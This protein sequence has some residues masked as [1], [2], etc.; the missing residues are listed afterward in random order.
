MYVTKSDKVREYISNRDYKKALYIAKGFKLGITRERSDIMKLAY[1]CIVHSD[2]YKQ[3]NV[4]TDVAV[5]DGIRVLTEL[6][7]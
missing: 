3:L 6:Y 2:F 5:T 7:A 4:D 1:E